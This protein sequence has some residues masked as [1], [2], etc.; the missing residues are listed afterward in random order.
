MK[1][2]S[3]L[4]VAVLIACLALCAPTCPGEGEKV[5]IIAFGDSITFGWWILGSYPQVL[6]GMMELPGGTILNAGLSGEMAA[7]AAPRLEELLESGDYPN[8]RAVLF[9]E[10]ANDLL[11]HIMNNN[12][13]L[14]HPADPDEPIFDR[15]EQDVRS[16]IEM[17]LDRG[18]E[19]VVGTYFYFIPDKVPC[20]IISGGMDQQQADNLATYVTLGN[21]RIMDVADEYGLRVARVDELGI[22]GG[23]PGMYIDCI[24][25]TPA[26]H[27][28]IA[29]KWYEVTCDLDLGLDDDTEEEDDDDDDDSDDSS[30]SSDSDGCGVSL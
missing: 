29:E 22:L 4:P 16:L 7:Y 17:I 9:W 19:V 8:L 12:P 23:D 21:E 14:S 20:Y 18:H 24:H 25:P 6:E 28:P 27:V 11:I 26:G 10:G 5:R 13:D 15:V 2:R 30:D 3:V 1:Q